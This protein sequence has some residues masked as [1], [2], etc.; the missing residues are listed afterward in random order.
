MSQSPSPTPTSTSS[1]HKKHFDALD[2]GEVLKDAGF[3]NTSLVASVLHES[4]NAH[5]FIDV[6]CS[7]PKSNSDTDDDSASDEDDAPTRDKDQYGPWRFL[8]VTGDAKLVKVK[9]IPNVVAK[10]DS[11]LKLDGYGETSKAKLKTLRFSMNAQVETFN[12]M[13]LAG[14]AL[15]SAREIVATTH[16]KGSDKAKKADG[17]LA[18]ATHMW[19]IAMLNHVSMMTEHAKREEA[20]RR[21]QLGADKAQTPSLHTGHV[22]PVVS[23]EFQEWEESKK[24]KD[25]LREALQGSASD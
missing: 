6:V 16:T 11:R 10:L 15:D 23:N 3:S 17:A 13:C 24:L 19:K 25:S 22:F 12:A 4:I 20:I 5:K 14:F 2:L 1:S 21:E 7:P 18:A 8:F 9:E